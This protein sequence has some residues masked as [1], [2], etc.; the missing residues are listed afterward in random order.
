MTST[1]AARR[2][3]ILYAVPTGPLAGAIDRY[4]AALRGDPAPTT[5][6]TY[7]PH[8]TLT[9]FFRRD[10]QGASNAIDRMGRAIDQAGPVPDDAV[11][12]VG[13]TADERW[14]GL[15]LRSTWLADLA[16][17]AAAR[18]QEGPGDDPIRLKDWLHLS[19]AYGLDDLTTH[20]ALALDSIDPTLDAG[21]E[22]AL[23]ERHRDGA[24]TRHHG[25]GRPRR[26]R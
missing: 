19:L 26:P 7:P 4:F 5:A 10:D 22:V 14:V 6:Q 18:H 21:W 3:L 8:C 17:T 2:E 1:P 20:A 12:I 13:L 9:G 25:D 15:E 16:A 23:W 11:D 24:W